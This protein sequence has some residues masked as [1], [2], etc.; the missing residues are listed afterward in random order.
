M[1]ITD[2]LVTAEDVK[3][4]PVLPAMSVAA[5]PAGPPFLTKNMITAVRSEC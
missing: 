2:L 4:V 3:P 1:K 5:S